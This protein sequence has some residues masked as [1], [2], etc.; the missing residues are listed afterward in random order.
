M[1]LNADGQAEVKHTGEMNGG[2]SWGK[3]R[4]SLAN[5]A[6]HPARSG[7]HC[8]WADGD[9]RRGCAVRSQV[10]TSATGSAHSGPLHHK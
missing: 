9:A 1:Q 2:R 8:S 7:R 3:W 10:I 4:A 5:E 6:Q